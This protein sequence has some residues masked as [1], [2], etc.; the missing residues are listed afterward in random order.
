MLQ[1]V[2]GVGTPTLLQE[3]EMFSFQGVTM[4]RLKDVIL[5]GT[6]T[7]YEYIIQLGSVIKCS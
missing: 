5:A 2:E 1:V 4:L 3:R 6:A 7:K